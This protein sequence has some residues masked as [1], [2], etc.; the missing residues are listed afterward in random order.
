MGSQ[1]QETNFP[2]SA[3][4]NKYEP[5]RGVREFIISTPPDAILSGPLKPFHSNLP[6]DQ[7]AALKELKKEQ[8]KRRIMIMPNDYVE[9]VEEML[10]ANF[11]DENEE[12]KRNTGPI[13]GMYIDQ[14]YNHIQSYLKQAG[15]LLARHP[16]RP[17]RP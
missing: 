7:V 2:P 10:N 5:S 3:G 15:Q 8:D 4:E 16:P 13:A 1:A 9:R 11:V 17:P 14:H 12:E 6:V